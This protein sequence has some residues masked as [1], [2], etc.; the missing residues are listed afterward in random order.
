MIN[1]D[2]NSIKDYL[3]NRYGSDLDYDFIDRALINYKKI[4]IDPY[5]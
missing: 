5:L 3:T 4:R 1:N 2:F